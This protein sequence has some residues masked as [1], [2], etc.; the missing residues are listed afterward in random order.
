MAKVYTKTGDQGK[1]S[2]VSGRRVSKSDLIFEAYGTVDELNS[3]LGVLLTKTDHERVSAEAK[4]IQNILFNIGSLLARDGA[5]LPDYPEVKDEHVT[6][7]ET[8]IDTMDEDLEPLANFILPGGSDAGAWCHMCR[9][10]CRRAERRV[11]AIEDEDF[12]AEVM[13]LN[14]LSDYLF[15]LSRYLNHNAGVGEDIW[16]KKPMG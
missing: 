2:L 6:Y 9:T 13:F 4:V 8:A 12:T 14:R 15:V 5:K 11:V 1:T 3:A 16:E 7:L 10:I